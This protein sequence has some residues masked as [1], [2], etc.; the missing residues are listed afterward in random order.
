MSFRFRRS[1]RLRLSREFNTVYKKGRR[2]AV[3]GI[4]MWVYQH[5]ETPERGA[6]LGLAIPKAYG[7]AVQR[8]RLKRLLREVF[9][10]NRSQLRSGVDLVFSCRT[11]MPKV[12]YQSIES[13]V[14]QLWVQAKLFIPS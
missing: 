8:N 1:D 7:N 13:I 10:L 14:K 6:R 12:K 2:Y 9:R 11:W 4:V 3:S 5:P